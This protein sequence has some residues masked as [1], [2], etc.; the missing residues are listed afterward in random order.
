MFY[1]YFRKI[2]LL[3]LTLITLIACEDIIEVPDVSNQT[4]IVLAPLNGANIIENRIG[5]NW[6]AISDVE[7]YSIAV[8]TPNLGLSHKVCK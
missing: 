6:D 7:G 1:S 8:A 3:V 2:G 5:F 4:I